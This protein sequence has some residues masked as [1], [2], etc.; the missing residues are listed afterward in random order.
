MQRILLIYDITEDRARAKIADIC[1]DYGLDRI[2]YSTFSGRLSR[3]M[4]ESLMLRIEQ[5][6]ARR[7]SAGNIQ[8][9]PLNEADWKKRLEINYVE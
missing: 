6:M 4:Q 7:E 2:Q 3:N 9:I 1:L 8:L 5:Q